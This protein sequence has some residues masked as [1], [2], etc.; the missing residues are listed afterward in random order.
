MKSAAQWPN[1]CKK[2]LHEKQKGNKTQGA[3]VVRVN[4]VVLKQQSAAWGKKGKKGKKK[5]G[6]QLRQELLLSTA[7]G[8]SEYFGCCTHE[9]SL[10]RGSDDR[11][12]GR[13]QRFA[14]CCTLL[15][16]PCEQETNYGK[17]TEL[18]QKEPRLFCFLRRFA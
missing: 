16:R 1:G 12:Q 13:M 15:N 4:S 5:C 8:N 10:S 18:V 2:P 7:V 11:E 6:K 14:C 9:L 3:S 17:T